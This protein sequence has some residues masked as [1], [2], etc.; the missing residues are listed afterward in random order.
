MKKRV[1]LVD[2]EEGI[3]SFMA[4][5]LEREKIASISATTGQDA[6]DLYNEKTDLV[7]LDVKLEDMDGFEVVKELKK[8]NPEVKV[9]L[10][11]GKPEKSFAAKAKQ[12]GVLEYV[13]KPIDLEW[14]RN[15]V[16]GYLA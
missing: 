4:S 12:L 10:I 1:L 14:L 3:L 16:V 2:D 9:I 6:L 13:T 5:F 8:I 15:K 7:I 11:S